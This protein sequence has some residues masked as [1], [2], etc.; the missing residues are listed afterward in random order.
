M[1]V[2][3]RS[4]READDDRGYC[5]CKLHMVAAVN[6]TDARDVPVAE[7]YRLLR[8]LGSRGL[9][10]YAARATDGAAIVVVERCVRGNA[11][12]DDEVADY[13]RDAKRVA[14]LDHPNVSRVR[15]VVFRADGPRRER[16]HRRRTLRPALDAARIG[17][18]EA[19]A[20]GEPSRLDRRA[21]RPRCAAQPARREEATAQARSWRAHAGEHRR[22]YRRRH[23]RRAHVP[24]ALGGDAP[25]THRQRLSRAGDPARRQRGRSAR[26]RLQRGRDL[27]GGAERQAAVPR[28]EPGFD[29]GASALGTR[30][31]R[32]GARRCAMGGRA[33]GPRTRALAA[34]PRGVRPT[35]RRW[36]RTSGASRGHIW[37][38]WR[39]SR[40]S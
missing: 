20:R 36:R 28:F 15:D 29:R 26:R 33:R 30:A 17:S 22:R 4:I 16:F 38:P 32:D 11:F 6:A 24:R 35:L 13:V 10:T 23:A 18:G 12:T 21:H 40:R 9:P 25:G 8:E 27:V 14:E 37:E 3:S 34:D 39:A 2:I 7:R 5:R 31:A 19:S 1:A